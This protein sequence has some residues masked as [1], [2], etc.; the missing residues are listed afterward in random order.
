MFFNPPA[1]SLFLCLSHVV[2]VRDSAK[3]LSAPALIAHTGRYSMHSRASYTIYISFPITDK[4]IGETAKT[5]CKLGMLAAT[6]APVCLDNCCRCPRTRL[7]AHNMS[8]R[9]A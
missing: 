5:M 3:T 6:I 4:K 8:N 1:Q 2:V 9:T 7:A